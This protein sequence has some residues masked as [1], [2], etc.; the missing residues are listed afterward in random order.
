M[1]KLASYLS[2]G[3]KSKGGKPP[4]V[5]YVPLPHHELPVLIY[6]SDSRP[7]IHVVHTPKPAS[8]KQP[9]YAPKQTYQ[10]PKK[11]EYKKKAP[12]VQPRPPPKPKAPK[13]TAYSPPKKQ[14]TKAQ[15]KY[16]PPKKPIYNPP[17]KYSPPKP[18]KPIA[19]KKPSYPLPKPTVKSY[20]PPKKQ[21]K[22]PAPAKYTPKYTPAPKYKNPLLKQLSNE[23][24]FLK[25]EK[26][27]FDPK[28]NIAK[29][30]T[31]T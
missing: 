30:S 20:Y 6:Q 19:L 10:E 27:L 11:V 9:Q 14:V 1:Q 3:G 26:M 23:E 18:K 4:A 25:T 8:A 16:N 28:I 24:K 13:P 17:P 12:S 29:L 22:Q 21:E 31:C 15:T 5:K 2:G 7:P